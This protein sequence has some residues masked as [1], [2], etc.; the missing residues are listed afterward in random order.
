MGNAASSPSYIKSSDNPNFLRRAK[1]TIQRKTMTSCF[2]QRIGRTLKSQLLRKL[3][4]GHI[5][6]IPVPTKSACNFAKGV[7]GICHDKYYL[8]R[9]CGAQVGFGRRS[10]RKARLSVSHHPARED[11]RGRSPLKTVHWTNLTPGTPGSGLTP[12]PS[13]NNPASSTPPPAA[14]PWPCHPPEWQRPRPA[15]EPTASGG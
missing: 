15:P 4:L 6:Q 14:P 9:I 3:L 5:Q 12:Q 13:P 10:E 11:F 7:K 8:S 2:P 1:S